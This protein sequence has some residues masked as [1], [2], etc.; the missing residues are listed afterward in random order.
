MHLKDQHESLR[1]RHNLYH[2]HLDSLPPLNHHPFTHARR[3]SSSNLYYWFLVSIM[4]RSSHESR[5][6][7]FHSPP[8]SRTINQISKHAAGW[9]VGFPNDSF[10]IQKEGREN[11]KRG[12]GAGVADMNRNTT[13]DRERS[14]IRWE[15]CRRTSY[16]RP[17]GTR[18]LARK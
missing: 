3:L 12:S 16:S 1:I 13:A 15:L 9:L 4:H 2:I 8:T 14:P 11:G 10:W 18:L 5:A 6:N 17:G 7:R